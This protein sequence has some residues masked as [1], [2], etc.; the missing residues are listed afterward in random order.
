[1]SANAY[2]IARRMSVRNEHDLVQE[3]YSDHT[4]QTTPPSSPHS[5]RACFDLLDKV[6]PDCPLP[7]DCERFED[8]TVALRR[9]NSNPDNQ[10]IAFAGMH[11]GEAAMARAARDHGMLNHAQITRRLTTGKKNR[12]W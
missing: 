3:D 4:S 12:L 10:N 6:S 2:N 1:M 5:R 8:V 7:K 9:K 11:P